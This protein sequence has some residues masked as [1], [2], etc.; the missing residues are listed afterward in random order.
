MNIPPIPQS[1]I[2]Q[3]VRPRGAT[4]NERLDFLLN[5]YVNTCEKIDDTKDE[6][7]RAFLDVMGRFGVT[8]RPILFKATDEETKEAI[9]NFLPVINEFRSSTRGAHNAA[10]FTYLYVE[11]NK[12]IA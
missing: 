2:D 11:L 10:F 5:W 9:V 6:Y 12:V 3:A 8:L 7:Q 1:Y 4:V